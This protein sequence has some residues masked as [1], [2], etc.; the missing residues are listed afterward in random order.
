[1]TKKL[2][3]KEIDDF[4]DN[5]FKEPEKPM[6]KK[7][8]K[9]PEVSNNGFTIEEKEFEIKNEQEKGNKYKIKMIKTK[10]N[11]IIICLDYE[12][13]YGKDLSVST[14]TD[15]QLIEQQYKY[16][17]NIFEKKMLL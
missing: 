15:F 17:L 8:E 1:M 6:P 10:S 13:K 2:M 4:L 3:E 11:L 16:M 9:K 12:L 7:V 14:K 5:F